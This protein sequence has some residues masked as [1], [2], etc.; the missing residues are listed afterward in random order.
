MRAS[1]PSVP[2]R[3]FGGPL[4]NKDDY[5]LIL[6]SKK[7]N[8][9][10]KYLRLPVV[11]AGYVERL[12]STVILLGVEYE[13]RGIYMFGPASR[14]RERSLRAQ[15]PTAKAHSLRSVG[16]QDVPCRTIS[17]TVA[18]AAWPG[19][20]AGLGRLHNGSRPILTCTVAC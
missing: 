11:T 17:L 3:L 4:Q 8:A 16:S 13:I 14:F 9:L 19:I 12:E 18:L 10:G 1:S 5:A 7:L 15:P 6:H 20:M 2:R